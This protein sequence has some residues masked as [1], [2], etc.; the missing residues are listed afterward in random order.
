MTHVSSSPPRRHA[1]FN[2]YRH[3]AAIMLLPTADEE[4]CSWLLGASSVKSVIEMVRIQL[5]A[6]FLVA[7]AAVAFSPKSPS[8]SSPLAA[9]TLVVGEQQQESFKQVQRPF[10][11]GSGE[12]DMDDWKL[13]Y[14]SN[15]K[16]AA[17]AYP[18]NEIEGKVPADL[19]GTLF[20][21]G[22]GNFE[23]GNKRYEHTLDGD[24][25]IAS[26]TFSGDG[27]VEYRGRFVETEYF[28]EEQEQD[29]VLYRNTFG[30]QREGGILANALDVKLKNVA[31]TN[32]LSFGKRV[33]ALWEAGKP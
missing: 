14:T 17:S 19:K 9:S 7:G 20:R 13:C 10:N 3:A 26:W 31:N 33:F 25:F 8:S 16:I 11:D 21:N 15:S 22:P 23:R 32:A 2:S 28:L 5:S 1:I 24:G 29:K 18:C 30:T 6:L 27:A 12:F 4:T